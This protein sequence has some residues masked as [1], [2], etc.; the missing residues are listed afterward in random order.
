MNRSTNYGDV[1]LRPF[2]VLCTSSKSYYSMQET[3]ES[4]CH[5]LGGKKRTAS[6]TAKI[7][8]IWYEEINKKMEVCYLL[9]DT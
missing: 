7:S 8:R 3:I 1:I 5:F 9:I 6:V 2:I 4:T